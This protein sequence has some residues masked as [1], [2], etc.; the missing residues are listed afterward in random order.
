MKIKNHWKMGL[1]GFA[2]GMINGLLGTGGGMILVPL[3]EHSG[4]S[5]K[6]SHATS[7]AVILP[8]CSVSAAYYVCV[9]GAGLSDA[10]PYLPGG[11]FGA[12]LGAA[13]LRVIK[14]EVLRKIFSVIMILSGLRLLFP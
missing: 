11:I 14:P 5:E 8:V 6:E 7:L 4:L 9:G 2:A 3:L 1:T 13:L 10:L 12:L